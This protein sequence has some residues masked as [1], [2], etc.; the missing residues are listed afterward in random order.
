MAEKTILEKAGAVVGFGMAMA[1]DLAGAVKTA[2]G[3][4]RTTIRLPAWRARL[5]RRLSAKLCR[6]RPCARFALLVAP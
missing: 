2:V 3:I 5:G 1:E 4:P 6:I